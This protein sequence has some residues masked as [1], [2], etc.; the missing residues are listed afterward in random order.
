MK[1][2]DYSL[3]VAAHYPSIPRLAPGGLELPYLQWEEG[4]SSVLI[5][6]QEV[7]WFSSKSL[8]LGSAGLD[9]SRLCAGSYL[10]P[11]P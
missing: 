10:D 3:W 9:L 2:S 6:G 7:T 8:D 11:V 1:S 5:R 4:L